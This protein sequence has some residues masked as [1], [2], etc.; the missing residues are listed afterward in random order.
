MNKKDIII[1]LVI[2][3]VGLITTLLIYLSVHKPKSSNQQGGVNTNNNTNTGGGSFN[4]PPSNTANNPS[5][6]PEFP[7][8]Y[9]SSNDYVGQLQQYLLKADATCLPAGVDSVWGN[10]M[11]NCVQRILGTNLIGCELYFNSLGLN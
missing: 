10:D 9:G 11:E 3:F 1:I 2:V 5:C 8:Q 6:P 7:L 4:P